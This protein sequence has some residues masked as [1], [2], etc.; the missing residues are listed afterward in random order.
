MEAHIEIKLKDIRV[1]QMEQDRYD[2]VFVTSDGKNKSILHHREGNTAGTVLVGGVSGGFDGPA[3][4]YKSMG[5]DLLNN[6]ISSLRLDY[7][8]RNRLNDCVLDVLLAMEYLEELG[9]G[10]I[11]LVGWSFGGAVVIRAAVSS[12]SALAVVTIASQAYGTQG[13]EHIAPRPLLLIHGTA[14]PTLSLD[15]SRDLYD[16]AL[17]PKRLVLYEGSNHGIERHRNEML[18][19]IEDFM[20]QSLR[21]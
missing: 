21:S 12:E 18:D 6:G 10:R 9:V 11:G 14:D 17:E 5:H 7:R 19:L 20:R 2:V 4:I 1:R 8:R 16:R 13:I 3:S 15:C